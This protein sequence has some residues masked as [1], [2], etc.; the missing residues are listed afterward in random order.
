MELSHKILNDFEMKSKR[1]SF[2]MKFLN[3]DAWEVA[4]LHAINSDSIVDE[5]INDCFELFPEIAPLA[6][7]NTYL[8]VDFLTSRHST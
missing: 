8:N 5:A 6:T 4:L 2:E 7:K 3:Q 1:R